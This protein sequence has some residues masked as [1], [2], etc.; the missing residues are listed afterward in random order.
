MQLLIVNDVSKEILE[1]AVIYF[2]SMQSK[3]L[4]IIE[5]EQMNNNQI[6]NEKQKFPGNSLK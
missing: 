6:K 4:D 2:S 3:I 1:K 5:G